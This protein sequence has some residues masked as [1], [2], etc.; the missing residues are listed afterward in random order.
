MSAA[1]DVAELGKAAVGAILDVADG[2]LTAESLAN[3]GN[4]L[5]LIDLEALGRAIVKACSERIGSI[6]KLGARLVE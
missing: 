3:L 5:D 2:T 6:D 1:D 4:L